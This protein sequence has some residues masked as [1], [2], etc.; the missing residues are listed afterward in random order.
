MAN[1]LIVILAH[2]KHLPAILQQWQKIG[3]PG[4]TIL[5]SAGAYR[6]TS[7]LQQVGLS[8]I[9]DLF[10][11]G[12]NSRTLLAAIDDEVLLEEA[13]SIVEDTVGNL[14]ETHSA[15]YFV[16]PVIRAGGIVHPAEREA[17]EPALPAPAD[18]LRTDS[19]AITRN[20]AVSEVDAILKLNP[21]IVHEDQ[22]LLETAREMAKH[23]RSNVAC[24][25][26]EQQR[27][28]GIIPLKTLADDLFLA[29][30]PDEFLREARSIEAAARIARMTQ[31]NH[32]KDVM[33]P[34]IWVK[35]DEQVK[36]AFRKMHQNHLTSIPVVNEKRQVTGVISLL[37]LI[38]LF[39]RLEKDEQDGE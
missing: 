31:S 37:E 26:N 28:T 6:A 30:S 38:T 8:A 23:P 17:Q 12:E 29:V 35:R 18:A 36:D 14:D 4:A 21:S 15:L 32:A 1:L 10:S 22:S 24:V 20:T 2:E 3:L 25:V 27:L 33:L 7:W 16:I 9:G 39:S 19:G 5:E 11:R 34:P 13:I